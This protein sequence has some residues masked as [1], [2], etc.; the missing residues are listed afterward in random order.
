LEKKHVV[1]LVSGKRFDLRRK[2]WD[3]INNG[4]SQTGTATSHGGPPFFISHF[5]QKVVVTWRF[6]ARLYC[7]TIWL[8]NIAI[9]ND[10]FID[11]FPIKNGDF[12]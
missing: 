8:F 4:P 9:E 2:T 12:P 6:R 7:V 11:G 10:P 3:S 1:S 5:V